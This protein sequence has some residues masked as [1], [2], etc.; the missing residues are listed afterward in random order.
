MD[1]GRRDTVP[2]FEEQTRHLR[3]RG[4]LSG[5]SSKSA[6][7]CVQNCNRIAERMTNLR[8]CEQEPSDNGLCAVMMAH[9][10]NIILMC[11]R[12]ASAFVIPAP[13]TIS[14]LTQTPFFTPTFVSQ[15]SRP[16]D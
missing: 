11:L 5:I 3:R 8:P 16:S 13:A 9:A 14:P 12:M 7:Q 2:A 4:K 10:Q 6:V 1:V 15:F